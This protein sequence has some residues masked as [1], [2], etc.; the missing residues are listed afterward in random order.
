[1]QTYKELITSYDFVMNTEKPF[2]SVITLI[3]MI[4]IIITS[5]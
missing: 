5:R 3:I 4:I 2:G 1:M